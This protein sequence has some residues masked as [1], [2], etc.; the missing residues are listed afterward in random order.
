ME[1]ASLSAEELLQRMVLHD[2]QAAL[3]ELFTRYYAQLVAFALP[4]ARSR[5][6]AEEVVSDV[7]LKVWQKRATLAEVQNPASYLYVAVRNQALNYRQK[8]ENQPARPL[9]DVPTELL[10][11]LST[12]E[13]TMLYGELY[14]EIQQAVH[15]L[16]PQ[17]QMAFRLVREDGLK[18]KEAAA[19][20]GISVKTVEVQM[21][22]ALRK[23]SHALQ[24]HVPQRATGTNRIMRIALLVLALLPAAGW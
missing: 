23:I 19:V 8:A 21:G 12:P 24:A 20:M 18:Y 13:R 22:I 11:E 9:E 2:D 17:C 14:A 5:E 6:L 10:V 3:S 15:K 16:P 7:F 4:L 1:T